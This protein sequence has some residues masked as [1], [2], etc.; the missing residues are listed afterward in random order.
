[1]LMSIYEESVNTSLTHETKPKNTSKEWSESTK[2]DTTTI[3]LVVPS[4]ISYIRETSTLTSNKSEMG[5]IW[6]MLKISMVEALDVE[7]G[8]E[9]SS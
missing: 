3:G 4:S 8:V 9:E 5:P 2:S 6:T 1:M 7:I